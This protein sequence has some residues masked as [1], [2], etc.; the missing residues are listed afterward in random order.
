[1]NY[2]PH[3]QWIEEKEISIEIRKIRNRTIKI[4]HIKLSGI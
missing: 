1:M 2:L 4:V 3:N